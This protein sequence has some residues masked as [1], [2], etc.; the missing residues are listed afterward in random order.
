VD[1][2]E[3]IGNGCTGTNEFDENVVVFAE[4]VGR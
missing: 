2:A 4:L 3:L 1:S